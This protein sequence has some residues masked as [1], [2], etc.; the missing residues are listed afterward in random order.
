MADEID[1]LSKEMLLP[2]KVFPYGSEKL[3]ITGVDATHFEKEGMAILPISKSHILGLGLIRDIYGKPA[4]VVRAEFTREISA[5]GNLVINYFMLYLL[6]SGI[7]LALVLILLIDRTVLSRIKN[8][9]KSLSE[10]GSR[11]DLPSGYPRRETMRF[12]PWPFRLR[13][14]LVP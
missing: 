8:L 13:A 10:V 7:I 1:K 2:I 12:Q 4:L 3:G 9:G 6:I 14:C 11:G 5:M